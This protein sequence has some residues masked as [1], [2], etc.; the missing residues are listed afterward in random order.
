MKYYNGPTEFPST[1]VPKHQR[2]RFCQTS[3]TH[4]HLE[5][6]KK[7]SRPEG[8]QKKTLFLSLEIKARW[9]K[10]NFTANIH[11][12]VDESFRIMS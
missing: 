9:Y 6:V 8:L 12:D 2:I 3:Y 11:Y 4:F 7:E 1:L 10:N 5:C